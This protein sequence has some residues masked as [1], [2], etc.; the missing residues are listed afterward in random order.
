MRWVFEGGALA[1]WWARAF[2]ARVRA[3]GEA[4][5]RHP[6]G[7]L[8]NLTTEAP[9]G[10]RV[11]P[12]MP[13]TPEMPRSG[14]PASNVTR[15]WCKTQQSSPPPAGRVQI[16]IPE[17]LMCTQG[18]GTWPR[19]R[20][21]HRARAGAGPNLHNSTIKPRRPDRAVSGTWWMPESPPSGRIPSRVALGR[22][23]KGEIEVPAGVSRCRRDSGRDAPGQR[24]SPPP[25]ARRSHV[26]DGATASPAPATSATAAPAPATSANRNPAT[27]PGERHHADDPAPAEKRTAAPED[28]AA[29]AETTAC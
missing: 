16:S 27:D 3:G 15:A 17:V 26:A 14:S 24:P 23:R 1:R 11:R 2:A 29:L 19:C 10:D 21:L 18:V 28:A 6:R 20:V 25:A 9:A 13:H 5:G 8:Q 22:Y 7:D 12:R 4:G